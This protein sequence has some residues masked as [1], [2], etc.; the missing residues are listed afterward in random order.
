MREMREIR[1]YDPL[2]YYYRVLLLEF[3]VA[4]VLVTT[5]DRVIW[6]HS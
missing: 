2:R 5:Y 6:D 1:F 3:I 4:C